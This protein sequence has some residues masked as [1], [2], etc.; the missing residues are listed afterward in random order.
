M[1]VLIYFIYCISYYNII[2]AE[3]QVKTE[4]GKGFLGLLRIIDKQA[5]K[6]YNK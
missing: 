6:E 4:D 5:G 1:I 3:K 2:S